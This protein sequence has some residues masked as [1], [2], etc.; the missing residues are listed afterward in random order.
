MSS[1]SIPGTPEHLAKPLPHVREKSR[2]AIPAQP[3]GE[4]RLRKGAASASPSGIQTPPR[5]SED[6]DCDQ[7]AHAEEQ[8]DVL[9]RVEPS[10][11]AQ[12]KLDRD[13]CQDQIRG[14]AQ[15]GLDR[16]HLLEEAGC[17]SHQHDPHT[18]TENDEFDAGRERDSSH[19]VVQGE[20]E[21]CQLDADDH[22][23]ESLGRLR[24]DL[25][26]REVLILLGHSQVVCASD[27]LPDELH[28]EERIE[29]E[30]LEAGLL[31]EVVPHQQGEVT[32]TDELELRDRDDVACEQEHEDSPGICA[33]QTHLQ[34]RVALA[35]PQP[36]RDDPVDTGRRQRLI[37]KLV[38]HG[39]QNRRIVE[40]KDSLDRDDLEHDDDPRKIQE[41][42]DTSYVLSSKCCSKQ[43]TVNLLFGT[44]CYKTKPKY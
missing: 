31:D 4:I 32:T 30:L 2:Y 8:L 42:H 17:E 44:A 24:G 37:R 35:L 34:N 11:L 43:E 29:A 40:G 15:R 18:H 39:A 41:I 21:V 25:H 36:C 7:N 13:H 23:P 1:S 19:D 10:E 6:H 9:R 12:D 38:R 27:Q 28:R 16:D 22:R 3:L 20:G 14:V 5:A 26:I 33:E